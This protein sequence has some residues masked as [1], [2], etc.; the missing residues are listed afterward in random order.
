MLIRYIRLLG[1]FPLTLAVIP[2]LAQ[3]DYFNGYHIQHFTDEN[4]LPQ[5]SIN[6]LLLD[7]NGSL[8]LA[9]QVGL[10]RFDGNSFKLFDPADKPVMESNVLSLGKDRQGSIYFQTDDHLLYTYREG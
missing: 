4:G 10:I 2:V 6:N 7:D 5:N 1:I 3:P 8:W 9:S